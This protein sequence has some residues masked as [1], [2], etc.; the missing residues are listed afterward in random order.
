M[1][2]LNQC[3]SL[4]SNKLFSNFTKG[5]STVPDA[6]N[7]CPLPQYPVWQQP[8][9]EPFGSDIITQIFQC[10]KS[11]GIKRLTSL[12]RAVLLKQPIKVLK[13]GSLANQKE[14]QK[15]DGKGNTPLH[16]AAMKGDQIAYNQL[17]SWGANPK[18]KNKLNGTP[19]EYAAMR[20]PLTQSPGYIIDEKCADK[21]FSYVEENRVDHLEIAKILLD[22]TPKGSSRSSISNKKYKEFKNSPYSWRVAP[23]PIGGCGLFAERDIAAGELIDEYLGQIIDEEKELA[24]AE[25]DEEY[26]MKNVQSR[27]YRSGGSM[28]NDGFSNVMVNFF[29]HLGGLPNRILVQAMTPI[30]K[31][32]ELI[33]DYGA[34]Y[35]AKMTLQE[36]APERL[37]NAIKDFNWKDPLNSATSISTVDYILT[38]PVVGIRLIQENK[39]TSANLADL[40]SI[41]ELWMIPG[42]GTYALSLLQ[43]ARL[44]EKEQELTGKSTLLQT[45]KDHLPNLVGFN[46][47]RTRDQFDLF[48]FKGIEKEIEKLKNTEK[49][50]E[51]ILKKIKSKK[52]DLPFSE[53]HKSFSKDYN[54]IIKWTQKI[55]H[56]D[57]AAMLLVI[58]MQ[59]D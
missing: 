24:L 5:I 17:L 56:P 54:N 43:L 26:L 34:T 59:F 13:N 18:R 9:Q 12:H 22:K 38:T 25:P 48:C 40:C 57:L 28:A 29:P 15:T 55:H 7:I 2:K 52:Y 23:S 1:P 58:K 44:H 19:E 31:G 50:R 39:I 6:K 45:I 37:D 41:M 21:S 11:F 16:Y 3:A 36:S 10:L 42:R 30:Q 51:N 33:W 27:F 35:G 4:I 8:W 47:K 49:T 32:E 53:Y 20:F 14:L 46:K